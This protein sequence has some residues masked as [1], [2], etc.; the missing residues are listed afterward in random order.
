MSPELLL[1]RDVLA[2]L[3]HHGDRLVCAESCTA[4]LVS[5]TL[6]AI[7]GASNQ[8]CGSA[9]VYRSGTKMAWLGVP[10]EVLCDVARGDVCHETAVL[11]AEA[12]L[13]RTPEATLAVSITGHLGPQAP[14][15]FDGV[16]FIGWARQ[17]GADRDSGA[18][19]IQ[20]QS[21][22]PIDTSDIEHRQARQREAV[23]A[24]LQTVLNLDHFVGL[25]TSS[26]G[27]HS[28]ES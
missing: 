14:E 15:G 22:A 24:V 28:T 19:R 8:L 16:A 23:C 12:A 20:L 4:G 17:H 6:A 18:R 25:M 21:P 13:T 7:P 27:P 2:H 9:V 11:M 10:E 5:A 1:A 26:V 3:S